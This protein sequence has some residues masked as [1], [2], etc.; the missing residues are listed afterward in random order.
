MSVHELPNSE[1][2]VVQSPS[3]SNYLQPYG[4]QHSRLPCPPPS[5]RVCSNSYSSSQW[6]YPTIACSM[7]RFSSCL[8]L[9][10]HKCLFQRVGSSHQ[11]A[12]SVRA[13]T[14]ASQSFQWI[15]RVDFQQDWLVWSPCS[16]SF[17]G[18]FSHSVVSDAFCNSMDCSTPD[19]PVL[20]YLPYFAHSHVHW[21]DDTIQPSQ[22]FDLLNFQSWRKYFKFSLIL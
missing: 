8:H 15:F 14:S 7:T 18:L 17:L 2:F 6:C 4:L 10:Q 20:H 9:S 5:P 11:V 16:P 12:Q 3:L 21:V 19:F 13:S 22:K 1:F